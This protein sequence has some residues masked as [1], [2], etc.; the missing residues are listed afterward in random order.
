MDRY[1]ILFS[2]TDY[3]LVDFLL[4]Y[5][6]ITCPAQKKTLIIHPVAVHE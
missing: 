4:E 2:L 5:F 1:I 3:E 6:L